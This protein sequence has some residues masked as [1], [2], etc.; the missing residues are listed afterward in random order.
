MPEQ[1]QQDDDRQRHAEQPKQ[2]S[3]SK[4]HLTLL[5]LGPFTASA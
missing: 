2:S 3:F 1:R 4:T 5:M